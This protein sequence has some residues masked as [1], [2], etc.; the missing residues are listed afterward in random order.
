MHNVLHRKVNFTSFVIVHVLAFPLNDVFISLQIEWVNNQSKMCDFVRSSR[1]T[2]LKNAER[3]RA[4]GIIEAGLQSCDDSW[5]L[6]S[7][8]AKWECCSSLET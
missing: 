7:I 3:E 2:R 4:I 6:K 8:P 5:A 1:M